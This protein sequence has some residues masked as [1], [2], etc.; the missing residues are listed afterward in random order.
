MSS[1]FVSELHLLKLIF[2]FRDFAF[3]FLGGEQAMYGGIEQGLLEVDEEGFQEEPSRDSGS[4]C[5]D[6]DEE[7][8]R[9]IPPD[10]STG[11]HDYSMNCAPEETRCFYNDQTKDVHMIT[12][13]GWN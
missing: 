4:E 9:R 12:T 6:Y 1:F 2:K 11:D 10:Q 13:P 8:Y 5:V 7:C 3:L